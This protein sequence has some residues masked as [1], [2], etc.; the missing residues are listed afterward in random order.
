[1]GNRELKSRWLVQAIGQSGCDGVTLR[2]SM[3]CCPS[4]LTGRVDSR[5]EQM[6]VEFS[7]EYKEVERLLKGLSPYP[8]SEVARLSQVALSKEGSR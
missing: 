3:L 1:M 5:P 7:G 4:M 2:P 8:I 6:I